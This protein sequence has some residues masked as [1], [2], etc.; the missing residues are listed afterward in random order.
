[1]KREARSVEGSSKA[2]TEGWMEGEKKR[3]R[4]TADKEEWFSQK[5][6]RETQNQ[7]LFFYVEEKMALLCHISLSCIHTV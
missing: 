3:A 7:Y 6:S 5:G 2:R 4:L 1:M